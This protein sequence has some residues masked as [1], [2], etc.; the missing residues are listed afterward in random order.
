MLNIYANEYHLATNF[1]SSLNK[2]FIT[3]EK[4]FQCC[5]KLF[6]N[7]GI[8]EV[9]NFKVTCKRYSNPCTGLDRP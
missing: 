3:D 9:I 7:A 2:I 5:V 1:N 4:N 8:L 6:N